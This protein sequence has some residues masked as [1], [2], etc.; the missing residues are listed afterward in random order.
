MEMIKKR[1]IKSCCLF[2]CVTISILFTSCKADN[3]VMSL[4]PSQLSMDQQAERIGNKIPQWVSESDWNY[5]LYALSSSDIEAFNEYAQ[6]GFP[7]YCDPEWTQEQSD[8]VY[9]G[10]GIELFQLDNNTQINRIILYPVILNGVIVSEY[11]VYELLDSHEIH[12]QG[13]PI[14][15]DE[16]NALMALTSENTPLLLGY[17]N[18]NLIGIIGNSYYVLDIDH[19]DKRE[20]VVEE[21]PPIEIENYNIINAMKALCTER[22]AQID[23]WIMFDRDN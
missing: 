6:K 23:D 22:T 17:N 21:I 7:N 2:L 4:T 14:I 5:P 3:N 16:L 9:L 1:R 13:G 11:E 12:M 10:Q 19:M 20:L 8:A 15:V 18:G